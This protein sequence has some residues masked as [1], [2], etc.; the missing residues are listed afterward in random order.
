S[1]FEKNAKADAFFFDIKA[2]FRKPESRPALDYW[3]L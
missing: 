3:S 1:W 2:L